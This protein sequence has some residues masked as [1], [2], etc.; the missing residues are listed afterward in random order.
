MSRPA[1][2]ADELAINQYGC[3]PRC[4]A[5]GRGRHCCGLLGLRRIDRVDDLIDRI[6]A[7]TD[8]AISTSIIRKRGNCALPMLA[9]WR[10]RCGRG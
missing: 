2:Y 8:I 5:S 6:F 1:E 9:L 10:R 3:R 4:R 7:M